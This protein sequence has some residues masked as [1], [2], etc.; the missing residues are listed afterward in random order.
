MLLRFPGSSDLNYCR[1]V[2][3]VYVVAV[4]ITTIDATV[5]TLLLWK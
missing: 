1:Y 3:A 5:G 4:E 2:V